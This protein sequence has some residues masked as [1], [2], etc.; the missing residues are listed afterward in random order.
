MKVGSREVGGE[1]VQGR[2]KLTTKVVV[3]APK[4]LTSDTMSAL[5]DLNGFVDLTLVVGS[6]GDYER[7]INENIDKLFDDNTTTFMNYTPSNGIF[8]FIY[9]LGSE[10]TVTSME[11]YTM[12]TPYAATTVTLF[13]SNDISVFPEESMLVYNS[14]PVDALNTVDISSTA[15]TGR[16]VKVVMTN[17]ESFII[18]NL[19]KLYGF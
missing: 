12:N 1:I 7:Y 18:A 13:I 19:L 3:V 16:Y 5:G 15:N 2:H 4:L 8:S 11:F 6:S 17:S 10:K 14:I 9:D